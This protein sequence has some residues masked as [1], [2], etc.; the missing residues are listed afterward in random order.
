MVLDN[1]GAPG[2]RGEVAG[3]LA[4]VS[5]CGA[6]VGKQLAYLQFF[7]CAG[8]LSDSVACWGIMPWENI[9]RVQRVSLLW[10]AQAGQQAAA[11][12]RK[13]EQMSCS[14]DFAMPCCCRLPNCPPCGMSVSPG[15][16]VGLGLGRQ[17]ASHQSSTIGCSCFLPDCMTCSRTGGEVSGATSSRALPK[18][19]WNTWKGRTALATTLRLVASVHDEM[20]MMLDAP[21]AEQIL[22]RGQGWSSL[23]S[24]DSS[25]GSR[26]EKVV[27]RLPVWHHDCHA[28]KAIF[29]G[30]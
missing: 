16:D 25:K 10:R 5:V 30:R 26:L 15:A 22:G 4:V 23:P 20:Q 13:S 28:S 17:V 7:P 2:R 9:Q 29:S 11:S 14:S 19:E 3:I 21:S 6:G 27:A 8:C 12:Q 24:G 1:F 18:R